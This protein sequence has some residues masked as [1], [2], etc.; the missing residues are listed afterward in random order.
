LGGN[1]DNYNK[2]P[3]VCKKDEF[4]Q[5]CQG[6]GYVYGNQSKHFLG[7]YGLWQPPEFPSIF[8]F[9]G[10]WSIDYKYR[11]PGVSWWEDEEIPYR[12]M[13]KAFEF[14]KEKKPGFVVSHTCPFSIIPL[15]PFEKIFGDVIH[16]PRTE[17]ML[18]RM[19]QEHQPKIWIFGHWHC[20][21]FKWVEHPKTNKKTLF[22]CL[23]EL[24]YL[25]FPGNFQ[26]NEDYQPKIFALQ[27]K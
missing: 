24:S 26:I 19:Y 4:C 2:T 6:K 1:H 8:F 13:L 15:I 14:Y 7:D 12:Q 23:N 22:I 27:R 5:V 11:I 18:E 9:R 20:D 21:F 10:A 16:K 25:D 17:E 3:C